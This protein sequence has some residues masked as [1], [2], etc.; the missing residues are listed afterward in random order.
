[1]GRT[2][3]VE[4]AGALYHVMCRGNRR[5]TIFEDEQDCC[6]FLETLAEVCARTGWEVCAYVLM[7][8]HYHLVLQTPEA[9][10][11][12]GM[13]WFQGI[14]TKRHNLRH[15]Q[16]GH[17]YQGR[18]KSIIIDP[19]DPVYFRTACNYIHL[20]PVRARLAGAADT[21][22]L[23]EYR[24]SSSWYLL[25]N[26]SK[27]PEWLSLGRIVEENTFQSDSLRAR[28]LYLRDLEKQAELEDEAEYHALRRGWCLGSP[29]FKAELKDGV[30]EQLSHM[31]RSSIVGEPRRMH[32]EAEAERLLLI[33][34]GMIGLDL[35]SKDS[36]RHN[37][38]RKEFVAWYLSRK[39][40]VGQG[41]ISE[42]L[43]MGDL[44]NVSRAL[45][46]MEQTRDSE[47]RAWKARIIDSA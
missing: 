43:G 8:N 40:S 42:R 20:N 22:S 11:V 7:P 16:W 27:T 13:K 19:S 12:R 45:M 47:K 44:S 4:Y 26:Q 23:G 29:E 2:P 36:L 24:W 30:C 17:V 1:M 15:K 39:T 6:L 33:A 14:Y 31:D 28:K 9:N 25:N 34:A 18:Y 10:L 38:R 35:E 3:R 21:V 37:D 32:D 46:R 41:W 5:E